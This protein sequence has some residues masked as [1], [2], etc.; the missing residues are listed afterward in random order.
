MCVSSAV[1]ACV[2]GLSCDRKSGDAKPQASKEVVIYSSIDQQYLRPLMK[3]FEEKTGIKVTV[4]T[5]A[6]GTKT[7]G[8]AEKILAEKANPRADVYWGNEPFHTINLAEQGIFTPY[9][10][11]AAM[12]VPDRWRGKDDLYTCMGARARWLVVSARPEHKDRVAKIKGLADL[13]DPALKGK[14]GIGHPGFGTTSGHIAAMYELRGDEKANELMKALRANDIK[15]LGGNSVVVQ[16]VAGGAVIA[17]LTDND[18]VQNAKAQGQQVDGVVPDQDGDGTLVIPTT[19]ALVKGGPNA[20]AAKKLIDFLFDPAVEKELIDGRFLAYSVRNLDKQV[21]AMDVD[22][23]KVAHRMR[24]AVEDSLT[25]L[26]DRA[27]GK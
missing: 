10:S 20:E 23:V 26:Q 22:Y 2:I 3:R 13:A 8:L 4:V 14:V 12:D 6:E 1:L 19:V 25:I 24:K 18:D 17:G 16:Q 27:A 15:M 21:K 11:P 5:D 7:A 9:R